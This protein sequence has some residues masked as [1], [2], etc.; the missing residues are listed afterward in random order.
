MS[1]D[2]GTSGG[3]EKKTKKKAIK[4]NKQFAES[5]RN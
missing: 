3:G 2:E 5:S 4:T 1:A